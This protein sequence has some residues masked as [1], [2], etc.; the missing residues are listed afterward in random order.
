MTK[1]TR[2]VVAVDPVRLIAARGVPAALI[3][4]ADPVAI[5]GHLLVDPG[6]VGGPLR[7]PLI[8]PVAGIP[9]TV[10]GDVDGL[11][12]HSHDRRGTMAA[13]TVARTILIEAA[14]LIDRIGADQCRR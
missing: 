5:R 6:V 11:G 12:E 8:R 9:A 14:T 1:L 2:V 13:L 3:V 7:H 4:A 10:R